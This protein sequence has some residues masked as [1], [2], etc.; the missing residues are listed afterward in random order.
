MRWGER[1]VGDPRWTV[2]GST[3][4]VASTSGRHDDT[5]NTDEGMDTNTIKTA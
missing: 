4:R 5:S 2:S 1:V 3:I